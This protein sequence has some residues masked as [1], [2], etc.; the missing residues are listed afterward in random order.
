MRKKRETVDAGSGDVF[1]DLGFADDS[2]ERAKL[3]DLLPHD[4]W[5]AC[6]R[7]DC[8]QSALFARAG[9]VRGKE[10]GLVLG[11]NRP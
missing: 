2:F 9:I 3:A 5:L 8:N 10:T 1:V 6:P 4:R 11:I 7:R